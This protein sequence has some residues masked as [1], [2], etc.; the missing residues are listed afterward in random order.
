M[1]VCLQ[2]VLITARSRKADSKALAII[3]LIRHYLSS[4]YSLSI[5]SI[6]NL[7]VECL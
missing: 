6:N 7:Y 3:S 4:V 5:I 2:L 1:D